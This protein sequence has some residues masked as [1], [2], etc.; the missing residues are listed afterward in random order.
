MKK[1]LMLFIIIVVVPLTS[2]ASSWKPVQYNYYDKTDH[3]VYIETGTMVDYGKSFNS[4]KKTAWV[5]RVL[6]NGKVDKKFITIDC[7]YKTINNTPVEPDTIQEAIFFT[8]CTILNN[9]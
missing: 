6:E 4:H 5:K 2:Y 9:K 8:A 7:G 3:K 1:F